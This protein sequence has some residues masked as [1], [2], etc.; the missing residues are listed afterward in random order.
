MSYPRRRVRWILLWVPWLF[1]ACRGAPPVPSSRAGHACASDASCGAADDPCVARRCDRGACVEERRAPG[2]LPDDVHGDCQRLVCD[3]GGQIR[4]DYD[5]ADRPQVPGGDECMETIC[6]PG[7]PSTAPKRAGAACAR[8]TCDGRG[9]CRTVRELASG[10][11]TTCVL[12]S[13]GQVDCWGANDA[14][15]LGEP[16]GEPRALSAPVPGIV[17]A[18]HLALGGDFA[19]VVTKGGAVS[20]WGS[21][22]RGELGVREAGSSHVPIEVPGL[23]DVVAIALGAGHGCAV[24]AD[25]V[26]LC[27][28][29][30]ERHQI[31]PIGDLT[32]SP[33]RVAVPRVRAVA[34]GEA[35]TCALTDAGVLCWGGNE[36]GQLGDGTQVERGVP[37]AVAGLTRPTLLAAGRRHTCAVDASGLACWGWNVDG[38]VGDGSRT[39]ALVP[40]R[41]SLPGVTALALGNGHSC[42]L[43]GPRAHCWGWN[44][45]GQLGVREP[46]DAEVP[47]P[48]VE[49]DA[50]SMI[51]LGSRHTC[52]IPVGGGVRCWGR[53]DRGQLGESP[54]P[55]GRGTAL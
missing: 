47:R 25:G 6:R 1:V 17:D 12:T 50:V 28:G 27:W 5:P 40:A 26:L 53:N 15:Q 41:V 14:G 10:R 31:A 24:Q 42:G 44:A 8:G 49:V 35:H 23:R 38:Q 32:L 9:A 22:E 18:A 2:P 29:S 51:S 7:G 48:V 30:N 34:A 13:D 19:C 21:N 36:V 45:D 33:T 4:R 54:K 37:K 52:A 11:Y 46:G 55:E 16:A 3:G 20:C 39:D 43:V